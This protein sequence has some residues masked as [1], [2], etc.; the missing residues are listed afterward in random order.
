MKE[1]ELHLDSDTFQRCHQVVSILTT[2]KANNS[3]FIRIS[4]RRKNDMTEY[5]NCLLF[6]VMYLSAIYPCTGISWL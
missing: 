1:R 3:D 5:R 6:F 4:K 2:V